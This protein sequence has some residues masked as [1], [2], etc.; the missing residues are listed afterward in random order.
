[1]VQ[2]SAQRTGHQGNSHR[3]LQEGGRRKRPQLLSWSDPH[4]ACLLLPQLPPGPAPCYNLCSPGLRA[5]QLPS[6]HPE[7]GWVS[8]RMCAKKRQAPCSN[9]GLQAGPVC[10]CK[11]RDP[12]GQP[13]DPGLTA[14]KVE[15]PQRELCALVSGPGLHLL[16]IGQ[17]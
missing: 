16:C 3:A 7:S 9:G 15:A 6:L 14:G 11:P 1:M 17:H 8:Y 10:S 4:S 2:A 13:S 5:R 12:H